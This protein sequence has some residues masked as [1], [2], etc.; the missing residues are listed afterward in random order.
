MPL[1]LGENLFGWKVSNLTTINGKFA[2]TLETQQEFTD[3]TPQN[4]VMYHYYYLMTSNNGESWDYSLIKEGIEYFNIPTAT[5]VSE[6]TTFGAIALVSGEY[7]ILANYTVSKTPTLI[8]S[9]PIIMSEN[10]I[11]TTPDL[12]SW[13][14]EPLPDDA[15]WTSIVNN[16]GKICVVG[17]T[18]SEIRFKP[19]IA[20]NYSTKGSTSSIIDATTKSSDTTYSYLVGSNWYKKFTRQ[21]KATANIGV[22]SFTLTGIVLDS[23]G[24]GYSS[25]PAI[26]FNGNADVSATAI[27]SANNVPAYFNITGIDVAANSGYGPVSEIT[28]TITNA[29][30]DTTGSGIAFSTASTYRAASYTITGIQMLTAGSGYLA[31]PSVTISGSSNIPTTAAA[32]ILAPINIVGVNLISGGFGFTSAPTIS[33]SNSN[34]AFTT[35][36]GI[37]NIFTPNFSKLRPYI[38]RDIKLT[39]AGAGYLV[40]PKIEIVPTI[41]VEGHFTGAS[42]TARLAYEKSG[43]G[44]TIS[45]SSDGRWMFVSAS[46]AGKV[47]CYRKN[48]ANEFKLAHS[49]V[50]DSS[51]EF[52]KSLACSFNGEILFVGSPKSEYNS[53]T[54]SGAVYVYNIQ[55]TFFALIDVLQPSEKQS[56]GRFG[57]TLLVTLRG[58]ELLV[59]APGWAI[60][61]ERY[62]YGVIHR[63]LI[64]F[65]QNGN[66]KYTFTQLIKKPYQSGIEHFGTALAVDSKTK[67][68]A[69]S[70]TDAYS[71]ARATQDSTYFMLDSGTT[72][73][74]DYVR[75]T[76]AV[77]LYDL[78]FWY[79][80]SAY[81]FSQELAGSGIRETDKYGNSLAAANG[82]IFV[83]SPFYDAND[84]NTGKV[85]I[86]E[87]KYLTQSWQ[88]IRQQEPKV[89]YKSVTRNYIYD[90]KQQNI[91][92]HLDIY[93]P[94]KGKLLGI[95][96][97]DIEFKTSF[98]PAAYNNTDPTT[99]IY[100]WGSQQVGKV[101]WDIDSVR[102]IDYEQGSLDYRTRNWGKMFPGSTVDVY[103]WAASKVKPS[104]YSGDGV[105]KYTDD[106]KYVVQMSVHQATGLITTTYYFWVKNKET[107]NT[108]LPF[109]NNSIL[110]ISKFISYPTQQDIPYAAYI[111]NNAV[112][113]FNSAKYISAD[114]A[115]FHVGYDLLNT[116]T[117][118]HNEFKL[119]NEKALT[120]DLPS[121]IVEKLIDSLAGEDQNGNIV[122]DYRLTEAERYGISIR[123]RQTLLVNKLQ[124]VKNIVQYVNTVLNDVP[125]AEEF[126]LTQLTTADKIP[127]TWDEQGNSMMVD[128]YEELSYLDI[129]A[130]RKPVYTQASLN[131]PNNI[132]MVKTSFGQSILVMA[133]TNFDNEWTIYEVDYEKNDFGIIDQTTPVFKLSRTQSYRTADYWNY[134]DWYLPGYD[135]SIKPTYTVDTIK[136]MAKLTLAPNDTIRVRD[137]GG[138]KFKV[139][140]VNY[141]L[142]TTVVGIQNGTIQ[143]S[144]ALW[145]HNTNKIGFDNDNFDSVKFDLNPSVELRNILYA[146]RDSIFVNTLSTE[147][148]KMFF[149]MLQYILSEQRLVDWVFKS[150]FISVLHN[151][152]QLA[153]YPSYVRDN[154]T[155]LSDYINEIK[156]YRTKIREFVTN[157]DGYDTGNITATDF[158]LPSYYDTDLK[159]WRSPN[160]EH[161]RDAGI[162]A[163]RDEYLAW[164]TNNTYQIQSVTVETPGIGYI[165]PPTLTVTGG[166]LPDGDARHAKL[167]AVVSFAT[168]TVLRVNVDSHGSGYTSRPTIVVTG[169]GI[170][171]S[172]IKGGVATC[173]AVIGNSNV[174]TFDTVIKL[175]RVSYST[176]IT[177]WQA[178][179]DY[180]T[181]NY[182][183]FQHVVYQANNSINSGDFFNITQ[184]TEVAD[185]GLTTAVDRSSAYYQPTPGMAPNI[186]A[187]LFSG[188]SYPGN[189]L[190]GN[191]LGEEDYDTIIESYFTDLEL[192]TGTD[193]SSI[194]DSGKFISAY[195]SHAPE[196]MLPGMM[197]DTLYITVINKDTGTLP[198]VGFRISSGMIQDYF[199]SFDIDST[200]MFDGSGENFD[201]ALTTFNE[202]LTEFDDGLATFDREPV[203]W[204]ITRVSERNTTVLTSPLVWP[205]VDANPVIHV[206]DVSAL[207]IPSLLLR[208]PGVIYINGER[209]T[210]Y[211]IDPI[212]NTL[213]Q[214]RRGVAGTGIGAEY[215]VGTKV[216]D[217]S[218]GQQLPAGSATIAWYP[219]L[220]GVGITE[221]TNDGTGLMRQTSPQSAFLQQSPAGPVSISV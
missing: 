30:G 74:S 180:N 43:F 185:H 101:W 26:R 145:S 119:V 61:S 22:T 29:N 171:N 67:Q 48:N 181:N 57:E 199:T 148:T 137:S 189:T 108:L 118:I 24:A 159:T 187:R 134:T 88:L 217:I 125:T 194:V 87:N 109:R 96:E 154:Q 142:S 111:K 106:S 208:K 190:D 174:R 7:K 163:S 46:T 136:D 59:G 128:S 107:F 105:P 33:V 183:T 47:Q 168:G 192:G 166:G 117:L 115:I 49:I 83:G 55:D 12:T 179:T 133:D 8:G 170:D 91:L 28:V 52:G 56:N 144:D 11:Y 126:D 95:A 3:G 51:G 97:D 70:S 84:T 165:V 169:G 71:I 135:F 197:Y 221:Y 196:E 167:T 177:P 82:C 178:N 38:I 60:P 19:I 121:N 139:F 15:R 100:C 175:D 25:A 54:Q 5:Q 92:A 112:A 65:F 93:D 4:Y 182:V 218:T 172:N 123:P 216:S 98:D 81:S 99:D 151:L 66:W 155:Y 132:A 176:D 53:V 140:A 120:N 72:T 80:E 129:T 219:A 153:Q 102:Y 203:N 76:G 90:K 130:L 161:A 215:P 103:E 152:R 85:A 173:Y 184:F 204:D 44:N 200:T 86:F 211:T 212:T 213:G 191:R 94:A 207:P 138:G 104:E 14:S 78:L 143:L 75:N 164:R 20:T 18:K 77:Y 198:P 186:P 193:Y 16:V 206:A 131:D 40:P 42:A 63:Y 45:I 205:P 141:D 36:S 146:L 147:F 89:D 150:S 32:T 1:A 220:S 27:S 113:L 201:E 13:T 214:L 209:I 127:F 157:Y 79:G 50:G 110:E 122:P 114:S 10:L 39:S 62:Y 9:V 162:I 73:V 64:E 41:N 188:I 158:D 156:P 160:G 37:D 34:A 2:A 195:T 23:G 58:T 124:G 35:G 116:D 210:Y 202:L 149:M 21:A 69:V 31:N 68:L 17:D 6:L